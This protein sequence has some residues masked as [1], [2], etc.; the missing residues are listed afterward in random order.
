M[1]LPRILFRARRRRFALLV[2]LGICQAAGLAA[3]AWL[4]RRAFDQLV[5]TDGEATSHPLLLPH[6][7][8][9]CSYSRSYGNDDA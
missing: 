5:A 7:C 8:F 3:A 4:S 6:V 1:A 9:P 2:A